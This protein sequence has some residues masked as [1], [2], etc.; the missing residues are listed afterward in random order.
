MEVE[1]EPPDLMIADIRLPGMGGM[2]LA[3]VLK[4]RFP[5]TKVI[6]ITLHDD[7]RYRVE[8]HR[9]GFSYIPKSSLI[10]DMPRML[11]KLVEEEVV[12]KTQLGAEGAN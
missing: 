12:F 8:A 6:L 4:N 1:K 5:G 10:E 9:L 3:R 11:E 7:D 2:E